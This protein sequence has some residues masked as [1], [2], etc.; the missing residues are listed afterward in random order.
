MLNIFY[1]VNKNAKVAIKFNYTI[2]QRINIPD[3]IMQGTLFSAFIGAF[4]MDRIKEIYKK[5]PK[6]LNYQ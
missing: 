1:E 4:S 6:L 2:T 5:N 3:S